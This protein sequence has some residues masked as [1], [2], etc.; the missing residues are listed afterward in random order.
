MKRFLAVLLG[1]TLLLGCAVGLGE[2]AD[3]QIFGTVRTNGEFT[4]IGNLPE[5]YR[6]IPFEQSDDVILS[7]IR[8][9]DPTRPEMVLSIAFDETYAD[10]DRMN[11]LDDEELA[12]LEKTF[13]D[14]DPAVNITYDETQLGTRLLMARTTSEIYDYLDI[15]SIYKGYFVEFVMYPGEEAPEQ[16]L[17]DEQ[18][19]ACNDFLTELDFVSGTVTPVLTTAGKTFTVSVTGFDAEAGTL[20]AVLYTP[21]KLTEWQVVS[22]EEGD[23]ITIGSEDVVIDSLVYEGDDAI[24]NEE[25]TLYPG[26]DGLYLAKLYESPILTEVTTMTVSVPESAAYLEGIDPESG[27][28]LDEPVTGGPAELFAALTAAQN[29]GIGFDTENV[30]LTFGEEGV[31]AQVE[32][33]YAEYQ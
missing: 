29:S 26:D 1:L 24:I 13:T 27:E 5:G 3:R 31:A 9:D 19:A 14:T 28:M 22:I 2:S 33:F 11:D 4:L 21:V 20:D 15:L 6:V 8:S 16:H 17:T 18:I 10:V 12:I 23:T 7:T 25:Y 30:S 32:R